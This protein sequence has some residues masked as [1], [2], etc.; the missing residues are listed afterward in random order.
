MLHTAGPEGPPSPAPELPQFKTG[1]TGVLN[2]EFGSS[3]R[4]SGSVKRCA[5]STRL[6]TLVLSKIVTLTCGT[7]WPPVVGTPPVQFSTMSP[8]CSVYPSLRTIGATDTLVLQENGGFCALAGTV[9]P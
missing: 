8:T 3:N 4:S 7:G 5:A 1:A 2:G 6:V 9:S